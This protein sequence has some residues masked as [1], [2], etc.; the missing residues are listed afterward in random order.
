MSLRQG[1]NERAVLHA[2]FAERGERGM[3]DKVGVDHRDE[4]PDNPPV[5]LIR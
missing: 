5:D 4:E 3:P 1:R 2:Q